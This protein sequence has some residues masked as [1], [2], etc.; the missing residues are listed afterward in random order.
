[1]VY[2]KM[3]E[4]QRRMLSAAAKSLEDEKAILDD[5]IAKATI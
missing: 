1:M 4:Q 2:R 5:L 3:T